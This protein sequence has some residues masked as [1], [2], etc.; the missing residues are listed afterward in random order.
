MESAR[1]RRAFL[2][3]FAER[4]HKILPSS[5]LIPDDPT[6]LLTAAGMVQFK[7]YFLGQ[8]KPDFPRAATVQKVAR[9]TRSEERRVGKECRL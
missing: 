8:K 4:G 5:S 7:P 1:I 3:F 2:D 6:L 9:T